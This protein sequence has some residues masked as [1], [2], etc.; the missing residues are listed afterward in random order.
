[1]A[2]VKTAFMMESFDLR[3]GS[4]EKGLS[5]RKSLCFFNSERYFLE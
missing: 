4:L 5:K 1:M 3:N 2:K